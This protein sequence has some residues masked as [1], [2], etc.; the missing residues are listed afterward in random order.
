MVRNGITYT[1]QKAKDGYHTLIVHF[2]DRSIPLHSTY[3]PSEEG[4]VFKNRFN[5]DKYDTLVVLGAGLGYHLSGLIALVDRY[6]RIIIIEYLKDLEREIAKNPLTSFLFECP[7]VLFLSGPDPIEAEEALADLIDLES[8]KGVQLL[9]HP[10]SVRAFPEYYRMVKA[11]AEK[12][13]NRSAGNFITKS[14]LSRRFFKNAV[15][16][17]GCFDIHFP[18]AHLIGTCN[19]HTVL[20]AAAGPSL[21]DNL[22]KIKDYSLCTFII[23]VDSALPVLSAGGI[24]PDFYV[25]ID[26]QPYVFEHLNT[27]KGTAI[28][29]ITLTSHP[30]AFA[31]TPGFLSLNTHPVAQFLQEAATLDIGSFHSAT[32][33]VAGDA[34]MAALKMG[35]SRIGLLG[36][37]S[38][39]P[40][41]ETYSRSSA[42]QRRWG[43]YA[44]D[45]FSSVESRNFNYIMHA[46]GA[47]MQNG[48]HTRRSLLSYRNAIDD[49]LRKE[50]KRTVCTIAPA[51]LPLSHAP[52]CTFEDFMCHCDAQ[53]IQKKILMKSLFAKAS[54]ISTH[55]P[56]S[57]ITPLLSNEVMQRIVE[58]SFPS[59]KDSTIDALNF[60]KKQN[61]LN[62]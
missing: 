44:N 40:R 49:M 5:P 37:D 7:A 13:I 57:A 46:S 42:Y 56:L 8:S 32:G 50:A 41:Y 10:A 43:I 53:A 39:F 59:G 60:F 34:L 29:L 45:R 6:R 23:A 47:L 30:C 22:T 21:S 31:P 20:V 61:Y 2:G 1:L 35:F 15:I 9:E 38:A 51:G 24:I 16:N 27:D 25:S 12:I 11:T 17:L 52:L 18:F 14:R 26:P 58:A 19:G 54:T 33:S 4:T 62:C 55:A 3:R 36:F 28:P 48:F